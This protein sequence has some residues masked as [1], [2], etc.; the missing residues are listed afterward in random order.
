[1]ADKLEILT[2]GNIWVDDGLAGA[3]ETWGPEEIEARTEKLARIAYEEV[4]TV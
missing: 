3:S 2:A 1:M 4:W